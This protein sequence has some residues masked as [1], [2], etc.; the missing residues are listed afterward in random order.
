MTQKILD[1]VYD[2]DNII[3]DWNGTLLNDLEV[4]LQAEALH[5]PMYGIRP[6]DIDTRNKLFCFPIETYYKRLGFDFSKKSFEDI[7][8]E[9]LKIY[10]DLLLDAPL[11]AGTTE[12]L[13]QIQSLGKRQY[14]LSAA[15]QMHLEEILTSRNI[16]HI[17]SAIYGLGHSNADSK[18]PRG[19]Q[20][21]SE[22]SIETSKTIMIGDTD[23]DLEVG[24]ALGLEVLLIA[25][26]HKSYQTLCEIHHKVLKSRFE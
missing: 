17:F 12:L 15:P 22:Q 21:I 6:P 20:L 13:L 9:F 7:N 3:W 10:Q 14:V 18:I 19:H 8:L 5:F 23:H 25:D 4:V 1:H 16:A 11:F 2:F 26:G 24:K